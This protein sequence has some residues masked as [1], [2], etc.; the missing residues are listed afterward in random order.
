MAERK[1]RVAAERG[2]ANAG[3][4]GYTGG[5][6]LDAAG[7]GYTQEYKYAPTELNAHEVHE[8]GHKP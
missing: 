5:A 8:L 6:E 2:Y 7:G 4:A 3:Y 1:K